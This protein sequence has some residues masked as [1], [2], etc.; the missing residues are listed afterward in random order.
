MSFVDS[1]IVLPPF[2]SS[3]SSSSSCSSGSCFSSSPNQPAPLRYTL[4]PSPSLTSVNWTNQLTLL[5]SISGPPS[6]AEIASQDGVAPGLHRTR[7]KSTRNIILNSE[8]LDNVVDTCEYTFDA[9]ESDKEDREDQ[10]HVV[11]VVKEAGA[12]ELQGT[13]ER[14]GSTL[15]SEGHLQIVMTHEKAVIDD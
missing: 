8:R 3:A 10:D 14:A 11:P 2:S 7:R 15:A 1:R 4:P 9:A 6:E 13:K 12:K 5:G